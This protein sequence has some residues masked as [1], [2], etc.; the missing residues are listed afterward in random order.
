MS[1]SLPVTDEE[2]SPW[3]CRDHRRGALGSCVHP[4][5]PWSK[6]HTL[7]AGGEVAAAAAEGERKGRRGGKSESRGATKGM[8]N[9]FRQGGVH[10]C[11]T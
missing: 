2:D 10:S 11:S 8:R 4:H 7:S 3:L 5:R 9:H 1:V 6:S